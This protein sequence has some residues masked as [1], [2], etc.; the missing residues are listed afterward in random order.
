MLSAASRTLFYN[1]ALSLNTILF[2][3]SA[4]RKVKD[5]LS[6]DGHF[7]MGPGRVY[8]GALLPM[9]L[10]H[11]VAMLVLLFVDRPLGVLGCCA[12]VG[13]VWHANCSPG[14]PMDKLGRLGAAPAIIVSC[15][16]IVLALLGTD[17]GGPLSRRLGVARLQPLGMVA[18][19][20]V[21]ALGGFCFG[22]MLA[23]VNAIKHSP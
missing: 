23:R 17:A 3:V 5:L 16:T 9:A 1:G 8:P 15:C 7:L 20:A 18:A 14:G 13:G 19:G 2:S 10:A 22:A 11:E 6:A 21:V 4:T 12:F